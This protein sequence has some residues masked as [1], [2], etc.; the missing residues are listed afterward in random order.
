ML[1]KLNFAGDVVVM[2]DAGGGIGQACAEVLGELGFDVVKVEPPEGD[3]FRRGHGGGY[4]ATL[5]R[6]QPQQAQPRA[7]SQRTGRARDQSG[8]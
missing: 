8:A 6:R 4:G 7:R 2:T 1:K 3:P 5:S